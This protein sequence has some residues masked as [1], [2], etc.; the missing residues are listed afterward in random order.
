MKIQQPKIRKFGVENKNKR[1]LG[2][3]PKA[4]RQQNC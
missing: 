3:D 1:Q 4:E 2:C